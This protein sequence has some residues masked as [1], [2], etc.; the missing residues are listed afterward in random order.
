MSMWELFEEPRPIRLGDSLKRRL[1]SNAARPLSIDEVDRMTESFL[2][3]V[4]HHDPRVT[5][6]RLWGVYLAAQ[7]YR[8]DF[9][10]YT[11]A[12]FAALNVLPD[13]AFMRFAPQKIEDLV[14][15]LFLGL[16][17][18][19]DRSG[20]L[21]D[22]QR[23]MGFGPQNV[24]IDDRDVIPFFQYSIR[25][26]RDLWE[27]GFR[28]S[29][30]QEI[31]QR[32]SRSDLVSQGDRLWEHIRTH[33]R[34]GARTCYFTSP[35]LTEK[36]SVTIIHDPQAA[37]EWNPIDG[38]VPI[39]EINEVCPGP[40]PLTIIQ[41]QMYG[42]LE[43][44]SPIMGYAWGG[45]ARTWS[46]WYVSQNGHLTMPRSRS[47]VREVLGGWGLREAYQLWR[48]LVLLRV[49]D[50]VVATDVA[51]RLPSLEECERDLS[52][53]CHDPSGR[54]SAV[55]MPRL[56]LPKAF[57]DES[58]C[59]RSFRRHGVV[60]HIRRLAKGYRPSPQAVALATEFGITLGE[61]ET[62]VRA[63]ERGE[64]DEPLP[65]REARFGR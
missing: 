29:H 45:G 15:D 46:R 35:L 10:Q 19:L 21:R 40:G 53:G 9:G 20:S 17:G 32:M 48:L 58:G 34:Y 49:H 8:F 55:V 1:V 64:G 7:A 6:S 56:R 47:G 61:H 22:V 14:K 42:T 39:C 43:D 62:F 13:L 41:K 65:V 16:H 36:G 25:S 51:E 23:R 3:L 50:L 30:L 52:G 18:T 28:S 38:G 54:L 59:A 11:N 57:Y 63:H 24:V 12:M 37:Y 2:P 5:L 44:L 4:R 26:P 60:W 31:G 33:R 27:T